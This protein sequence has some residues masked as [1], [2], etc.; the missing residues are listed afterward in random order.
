LPFEKLI[1]V[2]PNK[3]AFYVN[4]TST[5]DLKIIKANHED[6]N[7]VRKISIVN[8]YKI[9][10]VLLMPSVLKMNNSEVFKIFLLTENA[11]PNT[12]YNI[13]L[14]IELNCDN[15]T[16]DNFIGTTINNTIITIEDQKKEIEPPTIKTYQL[17]NTNGPIVYQISFNQENVIL[18]Y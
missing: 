7:L 17:K 10:T 4:F 9:L 1:R 18:Y 5:K 14:T 15:A 6:S 16:I 3:L 2:P 8:R 13:K 11:E 12:D